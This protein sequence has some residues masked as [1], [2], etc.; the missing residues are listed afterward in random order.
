MVTDR[1][2]PALAEWHSLDLPRE[3][4][5]APADPRVPTGVADF[6]TLAGG[7]P[8]GSVVLLLG[9][10]GAGHQEF[11]FTSAAHLMFH[12]DEARMHQ[13]LLGGA[14][15]NFV[16][17]RGVAYVSMT[18]SREQVLQEI[19]G[20]FDPLYLEVLERHLRFADLSRAYFADSVVPPHWSD[21]TAPILAAAAGPGTE[22]RF[23][24]GG[25]L[26]A[27]TRAMEELGPENVLVLDSLTDLVVRKGIATEDL[28]T[29]VK[30]LRRRAK[31]WQGLVYLLLSKG[32]TTP[33]TEQAL[34]DSVDGVLAFTWT[35]NPL[36]SSRQRVMVI[37]K[38]MPV[39]A[40]VPH[41]HQGRFVV[42]ISALTGLV[43]TQYERI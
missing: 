2:M 29:L 27:I 10:A 15:G 25:A 11:A 16:Y 20:S 18:R 13:F 37:P 6:D 26:G 38:F 14:R 40:H 21:G 7:L 9:D 31:S 23:E 36:R 24:D 41:E 34:I 17:P 33:D 22:P 28:L 3:L 42:R 19:Q 43:T 12:H 35:A 8:T 32:V 5:P 1:P 30:G 4:I 39:L